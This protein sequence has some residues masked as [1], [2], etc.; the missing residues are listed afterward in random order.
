MA[1]TAERAP[2]LSGSERRSIVPPS[3]LG[4][5]SDAAEALR[6]LLALIDTLREQQDLTPERVVEFSGV[7]LRES[8]D[9]PRSFDGHQGLTAVWSHHYLLWPE[10]RARPAVLVFWFGAAPES[11]GRWPPKTGICALDMDQFHDA[12]LGMGFEN[13][14][15]VRS[16]YPERRYRRGLVAVDA[17]YTGEGPTRV[18]HDC[19]ERALVSFLP[20]KEISR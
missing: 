11:H 20:E 15:N 12:L 3:Q 14:G 16:G 8:L 9:D 7:A 2:P 5:A 17:H 6:R 18:S 19:I 4:P 13:T 1:A 10:G